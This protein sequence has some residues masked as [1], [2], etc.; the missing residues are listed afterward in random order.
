MSGHQLTTTSP[1]ESPDDVYSRTQ[2]ETTNLETPSATELLELLGDE[3]TRA[4]LQAV[5]EQSRTGREIID[6]TEMSKATVYR[7]LDELQDAG[8]VESRTSI[9][10]DGHHRE[11]FHAVLEQLNVEV[12]QD[13]FTANVQVTPGNASTSKADS[14]TVADD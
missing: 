10:P 4:V 6:A 8:V 9:D 2:T 7:R 13:G 5:T 3:Y 14:Y 1:P 11:E 12:C